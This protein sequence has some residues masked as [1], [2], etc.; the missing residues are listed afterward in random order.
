MIL[1]YNIDILLYIYYNFIS[2][3]LLYYYLLFINVLTYNR[4]IAFNS[5]IY[6]RA[7]TLR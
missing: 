5:N 2:I 7:P 3:L 6:P 1:I 4:I